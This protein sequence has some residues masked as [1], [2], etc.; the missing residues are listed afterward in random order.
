MTEFQMLGI[1]AS[2]VGVLAIILLLRLLR[3]RQHKNNVTQ[4]SSRRKN[5]APSSLPQK[6]DI[7]VPNLDESEKTEPN[8]GRQ[9]QTKKTE[10]LPDS[11]HVFSSLQ[12]LPNIKWQVVGQTD[13]GLKRE[14]NEDNFEMI[15]ISLPSSQPCG[16]YIVAD[17]MGGHEGGEIASEL[18]V[19]TIKQY[20]TDHPPLLETEAKDWLEKAVMMANEMVIS[21]QDSRDQ[22]DKMGSTVVM[23]LVFDKKAYVTNVGDSRTYLINSNIHKIT[24]DHSLVERLVE[25]GQITAEEART[26]PQRNVIYSTIGINKPKMDIGFYE[27]E[28]KLGDR[29]LLCSDGLSGLIEDEDLFQLSQHYHNPVEACQVMIESAKESGG[30]DNITVIIVQVDKE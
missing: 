6:D 28:L 18:T 10:Q 5:A 15:E 29:L 23:A 14:L 25:I 9:Q 30:Y 20:F 22:R 2:M 8:F 26:H 24:T 17:G 11:V 21:Q 7:T 19:T 16:L 1:L 13:V 27:V 3:L 4:S 12:R